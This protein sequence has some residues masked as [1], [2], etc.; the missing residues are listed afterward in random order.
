MNNVNFLPQS[1]RERLQHRHRYARQATLVTGLSLCLVL[2]SGYL[3]TDL[4]IQREETHWIEDNLA[5][6]IDRDGNIKS[7]TK[8]RDALKEA[9]RL[10]HELEPPIKQHQVVDTLAQLMPKSVSLSELTLTNRRPGPAAY[11]PPSAE[12]NPDA[13]RFKA[14]LKQ[15]EQVE[16]ITLVEIQGLAPD[17]T[18][19][20]ELIVNLSQHPLF[21][22]VKLRSS[23]HTD[24]Q[25]VLAREFS[26]SLQVN[27]K[28]Q[29]TWA[30]P[31]SLLSP[32]L[33][34]TLEVRDAVTP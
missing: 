4:S 12:T 15:P 7:L 30:E 28:N 26:L 22:R 17:D 8:E 10:R 13:A 11:V 24:T 1:Y 32:A 34:E 31:T 23:L 14:K 21:E 3:R 33:A 6:A 9:S 25:G 29:F 2:W 20:A 5:E 16:D 19:V 18:A 27:L